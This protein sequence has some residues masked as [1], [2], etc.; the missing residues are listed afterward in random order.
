M[1][2]RLDFIVYLRCMAL[3]LVVVGHGL[4]TYSPIWETHVTPIDNPLWRNVVGLIYQ[5]H[6]PVF[7]M[8]S[9]YLYFYIRKKGG[10]DSPQVF[11]LKK[12]KRL[13]I[14]LLVFG[15]FECIF[16]L[17]GDFKSLLVGP[18]HL[19]Y[20]YFL[21]KCF[22]VTYLYDKWLLKTPWLILPLIMVLKVESILF[23]SF[24][25]DEHFYYL[26]PFFLIGMWIQGLE[27][28][29]SF[30]N[31][32]YR[33]R[34]YSCLLLAF[35]L[36]LLS[37]FYKHY[38]GLI[39]FLFNIILFL[40]FYVTCFPIV[41][42]WLKNLDRCSMGIYLIHHPIIWNFVD[43]DWGR[44]LLNRHSVIAPT[45]LIT[46]TFSFSWLVSILLLKT[47]FLRHIIG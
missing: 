42:D 16:D 6:M 2:N 44:D 45:L 32:L 17:N 30:K 5:I 8:I 22:I 18:L 21:I 4:C 12:L 13:M 29:E 3:L 46:L 14:P 40:S 36:F 39:S 11:F 33:Q 1:A 24:C 27:C 7:S 31:A 28:L 41:P 43:N 38:L 34:I 25:G 9:G 37:F 15:L 35:V 26:Y 23:P 10:Y 47:R 19:W 20:L